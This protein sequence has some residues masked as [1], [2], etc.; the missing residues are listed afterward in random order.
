MR[1]INF[2]GNFL[3]F[4]TLYNSLCNQIL[5]LEVAHAFYECP[6]VL[7]LSELFYLYI[8]CSVF[9]SYFMYV[10]YKILLFSNLNN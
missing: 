8:C 3:V 4:I 2:S 7:T 9:V 6:G 10:C 5:F 1:L